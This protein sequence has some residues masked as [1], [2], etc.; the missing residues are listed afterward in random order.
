MSNDQTLTIQVVLN[1]YCASPNRNLGIT[2]MAS[3]L[4]YGGTIYQTGTTSLITKDGFGDGSTG[5]I[6]TDGTN[7]RI[8]I[9]N[10]A[11]LTTNWN[12]SYDYLL[13]T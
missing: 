1:A 6:D 10:G 5:T 13:T 12:A 11:G 7:V 9:T 3:F 4:K 8:R 2:M